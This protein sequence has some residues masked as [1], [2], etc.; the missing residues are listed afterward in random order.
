MRKRLIDCMNNKLKVGDKVRIKQLK[1][2]SYDSEPDEHL[3]EK[4]KGE[5]YVISKVLSLERGFDYRVGRNVEQQKF[6]VHKED[7]EK[8]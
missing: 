8:V 3:T 6:F 7:I 2:D 5:I 1:K 4:Y